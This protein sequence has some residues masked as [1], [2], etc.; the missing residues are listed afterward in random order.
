MCVHGFQVLVIASL[1]LQQ[2]DH[3]ERHEVAVQA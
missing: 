2:N 3:D 1:P